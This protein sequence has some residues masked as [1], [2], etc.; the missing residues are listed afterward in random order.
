[1]AIAGKVAITPGG[2]WSVDVAYDK[3]VVVT[4]GNNVYLSIKPSTGIE[5]TN[6]EHW[7]LLIENVTQ[8]QYDA[9]I[10]GTTAVGNANKLGGKG[11]SEYA[12]DTYALKNRTKSIASPPTEV[13]CS[14]VDFTDNITIDDVTF[15]RYSKG[16]FISNG[17]DGVL[18]GIDSDGKLRTAFRN[19]QTWQNP[20]TFST[21]ADLANYLP[22]SGGTLS[23]TLNTNSGWNGLIGDSAHV[24]VRARSAQNDDK[25]YR[26]LRILNSTFESNTENALE[27]YELINGVG[28]S[29]KILHTGNKPSGAYTGN[30]SA[31]ARTVKV[32]GIGR[33]LMVRRVGSE[34]FAI[35]TES[36]YIGRKG[37]V[38]VTGADAYWTNDGGGNLYM[39]T[40]SEIFNASGAS[41]YYELL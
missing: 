27:F 20:R 22:K 26:S 34:D 33:C 36:G 32:G 10:N 4:F 6:E 24:Q 19:G 37:G 38:V 21:A 15:P 35:V 30:G 13:V 31:T 39:A 5:P 17:G 8:E 1:M 16:I 23:G 28:S 18:I 14:I 3:L 29:R 7:M 9:I 12:L 25:N 11:A 40:T 41:H 2:E